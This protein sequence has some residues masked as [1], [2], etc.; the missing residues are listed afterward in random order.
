MAELTKRLQILL[1]EE[2]FQYLKNLSHEKR[3]SVGDLVRSAVART[4]RPSTSV[5]QLWALK[6]I[7]EN[8]YL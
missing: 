5:S 8:E 7:Q 4:Y 3:R 2:E 1:T 6:D